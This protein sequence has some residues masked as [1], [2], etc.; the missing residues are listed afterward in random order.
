VGD[1]QGGASVPIGKT[2]VVGL[3]LGGVSAASI[4]DYV[5]TSPECVFRG[6]I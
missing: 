4:G 3:G 5:L 1:P 6:I 2:S